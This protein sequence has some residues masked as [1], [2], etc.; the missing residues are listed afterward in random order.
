MIA[1]NLPSIFQ[2][3]LVTLPIMAFM[4]LF[5]SPVKDH[6]V[7]LVVLSLNHLLAVVVLVFHDV[8]SFTENRLIFLKYRFECVF[9]IRCS[10][11][12]FG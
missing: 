1:C 3:C 10:L 9:M 8:D 6:K 5:L 4:L 2:F 12:I 11:C 7:Y